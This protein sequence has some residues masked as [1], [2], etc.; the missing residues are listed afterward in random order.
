MFVGLFVV[1]FLTQ[2]TG[3]LNIFSKTADVF[4]VSATEFS[5]LSPL[6]SGRSLVQSES[7]SKLFKEQPTLN[8]SLTFSVWMLLTT[9]TAEFE[10]KFHQ[11]E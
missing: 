6:H 2:A 3:I 4:K 5:L 8:R 9:E 1:V 7:L 10:P 11:D